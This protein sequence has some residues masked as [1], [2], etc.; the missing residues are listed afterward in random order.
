[1]PDD[2]SASLDVD[3]LMNE[4]RARVERRRAEGATPADVELSLE[5]HFARLTGDRPEASPPVHRELDE[6]RRDLA[7]YEFTRAAFD[8][9]SSVPGGR[10]AHQLVEKAVARQTQYVLDQVQAYAREVDRVIDLLS[11][12]VTTLASQYD[13]RVLQQLDDLQDGMAELR[14]SMNELR[15]GPAGA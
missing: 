4:L 12:I 11:R 2:E 7:R 8:P 5:R 14:A 10:L 6:A 9:S 1:V 15:R 13:T 3:A